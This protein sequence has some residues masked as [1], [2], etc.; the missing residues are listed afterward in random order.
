[1]MFKYMISIIN[2]VLMVLLLTFGLSTLA[3]AEGYSRKSD[4]LTDMPVFSE[5]LIFGTVFLDKNGNGIQDGDEV[6]IAGVSLVTMTGDVV[7]TDSYGRYSL[8]GAKT[9]NI[10]HGGNFVIKLD[11]SS[12]PHG[13]KVERHATAVVRL[14]TSMPR[15][16]DFPIIKE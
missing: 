2:R 16:I 6:G 10:T 7:V 12:L 3:F 13:F 5:S 14:T 15:Q 8:T 4:K 9:A 1:M 11:S